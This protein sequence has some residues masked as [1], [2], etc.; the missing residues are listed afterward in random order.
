MNP[1]LPQ[2]P[3]H[4]PFSAEQRKTLEPILSTLDSTQA[5]WLSG[6]LAG[7]QPAT[8]PQSAQPVSKP[9]AAQR[10]EILFGSESGNAESLAEQTAQAARKSGFKAVVKGMEEANVED[11]A[12]AENLLVLVSTWG[13]GDPPSPAEDYYE[14]FMSDQAPKLTNTRFSVLA[15][16]DTSYEHFCKIGKDFD[17][18]LEKL[19]GTRVFPR[20]DCDVDFEPPFQ[21]WLKGALGALRTTSGA[22]SESGG[23][24]AAETAVAS[25]PALTVYDRKNPFPAPLLENINLNSPGSETL[26]ASAKETRHLELSLEGSGLVYEPGDSLGIFPANCPEVVEDILSL[27]KFPRD[28]IVS[29]DE[30]E[31]PLEQALLSKL[32]I[33]GLTQLFLRKYAARAKSEHLDALLEEKDKNN[34]KSYLYG[35]EISDTLADFPVSDLAPQELVSLLR[36]MP[37][38]LYSIASSLKAHPE[39]VHL[40]VA[41][42]RYRANGK[43]RKGV[44]STYLADRVAKGE[45]VPVF[46]HHNK[47]FRLPSDNDTPIIMVGPGTGIAPFRA[48]VEE[49][50]EIGAKG[51]NWLFFGDQ[52]MVTDFLYQ[53]E[54]QAALKDG[55]LNRIDLAWSRD[56]DHKVYVQHKMRE[57]AAD[58]WKWLQDGAYF[59]VCGDASRMAKDVHAELLQIAQ[60]EGK[61]SEDDAQ[62]WL[63]G[64]QKEKRYQRDVY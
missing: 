18:R 52:H 61:L 56:T 64:L 62:Q 55:S 44:A 8:L 40:T 28:T 54:W 1:A 27:T 11:L 21:D 24:V 36:K 22:A 10:L 7:A 51:K 34:L 42:V 57:N 5:L 47:N 41:A 60:T 48:F 14:R 29:V 15:L 19:G 63:K 59:Y 20:Q 53:T 12:K 37:P 49:R 32:D 2:L 31:M 50:R 17:E 23:A 9:S 46:V 45:T 33:T 26:P 16:G 30:D 35:R 39:E 58:L 4:A 3:D 43:I 6:F 13:E 25:T 38:R